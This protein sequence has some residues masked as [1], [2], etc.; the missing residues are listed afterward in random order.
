MCIRDSPPPPP[1]S[2]SAYPLLVGPVSKEK[3]EEKDGKTKSQ[4]R[5][6]S[7]NTI[8][9]AL[10]VWDCFPASPP[11]PTS[12]KKKKKKREKKKE[13]KRG[14]EGHVPLLTEAEVAGAKGCLVAPRGASL[15]PPAP[16]GNR[17]RVLALPAPAPAIAIA[18][19]STALS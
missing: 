19:L 2:L 3:K 6:R 13:E 7:S 11:P 16:L 17:R 4:Y 18:P 10:C 12:P 5:S 8:A 9:W 1:F 15:L 14:G